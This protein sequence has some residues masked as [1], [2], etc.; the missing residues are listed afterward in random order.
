MK[1][2]VY[3]KEGADMSEQNSNK[4]KSSEK[5]KEAAALN[6][7]NESM[8]GKIENQNKTHNARKEGFARKEENW[9]N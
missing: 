7:Y 9:N 5:A 6:A 1:F 3:L 8:G 2:K 4:S